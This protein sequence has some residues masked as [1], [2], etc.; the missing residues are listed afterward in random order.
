V[1]RLFTADN[2]SRHVGF[3]RTHEEK[4]ETHERLRH[5]VQTASAHNV[6]L[7]VFTDGEIGLRQLPLAVWPE[8]SPVL[9]GYP[10]TRKITVLSHILH[11]RATVKEFPVDL[12]ACLSKRLTSLKWRLWHRRPTG[13]LDRLRSFL[14]I[15]QR[16]ALYRKPIAKRLR[17]LGKKLKTYLENNADSV[18]N[19]AKHFRRGARI[20]AAFVESTVNQL[21]DKR[22]SKSQQMR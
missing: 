16:R 6:T 13:G 7:S 22:M 11:S 5:W 18:I 2:A 15:L 9:D 10:L 4:T 1:G 12:H 19:Y 20:S 3:V 21:I 17:R 8:A 14:L